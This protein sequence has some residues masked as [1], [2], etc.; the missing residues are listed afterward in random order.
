MEAPIEPIEQIS[1]LIDGGFSANQ[2]A[3]AITENN[4]FDLEEL[5]TTL[6]E[7]PKGM[8]YYLVHIGKTKFSIRFI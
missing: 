6:T 8:F 3:L 7:E 2:V 1:F 5:L 4:S